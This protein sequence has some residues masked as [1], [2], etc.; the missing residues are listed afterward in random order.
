MKFP[1]HRKDQQSEITIVRGEVESQE[2]G[3]TNGGEQQLQLIALTFGIGTSNDEH[4]V[5]QY[6][7]LRFGIGALNNGKLFL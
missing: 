4:I 2:S 6:R 3:A 7:E 1:I 5:L